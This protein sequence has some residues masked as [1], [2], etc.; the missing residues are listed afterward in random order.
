MSNKTL[1]LALLLLF[2]AV[3]SL[4]PASGA[5]HPASSFT[6]PVNLSD[7][8]D[9]SQNPCIVRTNDGFLHVVWQEYALGPAYTRGNGTAWQPWEWVVPLGSLGYASPALAVDGGGNAHVAMIQG[10]APPY[11]V[12]YTTRLATGTWSLPITLS[13]ALHDSS[14]PTIAVDN[15]GGAWVAWQTVLSDTNTEIYARH[16]PA[17]GEWGDLMRVTDNAVQ[18]LDPS[19]AVDSGGVAHLAWRSSAAGVYDIFY[20]RYEGGGWTPAE[21]LSETG[22]YSVAPGLAADGAGNV[23]VAWADEMG[24]LDHFQILCR[25]WDGSAWL[26]W[27]YVSSPSSPRALYPALAAD[28]NGNLY[29][30]WT[31]Y[32]D[33]LQHP[34]IYFSHSTDYGATWLGDEN[35]SQTAT[36]SYYPDVAAQ[37]GGYA[38]IVWQDVS[39]GQ[40]DVFYSRAYVVDLE[41]KCYLPV[42]QK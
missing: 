39:P 29:A 4:Q 33:D 12:A 27:T 18:D 3:L 14:F 34:E 8:L 15:E 10:N 6:L 19:L 20:T 2:A 38:H 24:G 26:P 41:E 25:R 31:D 7:S 11:L 23:Y 28:D 21:N 32:R 35:V 40:L 37:A 30:V 42:V 13:Q 22:F 9:S 17:G 1:F 16:R 5:V 36:S